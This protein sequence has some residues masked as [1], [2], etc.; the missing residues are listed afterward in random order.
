MLRASQ[1]RAISGHACAFSSYTELVSHKPR[2]RAFSI[3]L[4]AKVAQRLAED[5]RLLDLARARLDAMHP[6]YAAKWRALL[7]GAAH[8]LFAT[9]VEDSDD[10]QALRQTSPFAFVLT[11]RERYVIWKAH[12]SHDSRAA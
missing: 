9:L 10:A 6:E 8:V 5:P 12:R 4:H 2:S 3:Q 1:V 11:S 7:D